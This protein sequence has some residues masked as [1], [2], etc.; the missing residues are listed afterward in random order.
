M[1]RL[2]KL[3]ANFFLL[4]TL[5]T[6]LVYPQGG[7][8]VQN[9]ETAFRVLPDISEMT[10]DEA[11]DLIDDA[12]S[13]A[14]EYKYS[15]EDIE[16]I[17]DLIILFARQGIL[18]NEVDEAIE[19]ERDI[20]ELLY[21]EEDS[22]ECSF[23]GGYY[24]IPAVS[25]GKGDL[26]LCKNWISRS[27]HQTGK[28]IRKK[29]KAIIIGAAAVIAVAT[30]VGIAAALTATAAATA[31]AAADNNNS[32]RAYKPSEP[33]ASSSAT[34]NLYAKMEEPMTSF[35]ENIAN[36]QFFQ[37]S[38]YGEASFKENGRVLGS[39]F[40]HDT[41]NHLSGQFPSQP[42]RETPFNFEHQKIDRKFATDYTPS[43]T[44]NNK[45]PDFNA[46]AYQFQGEREL[47]SGHLTQAVYDFNK[48]IE[49]NP[50]SPIPYLDRGVAHFRLGEYDRS[51][52]DYHEYTAQVEKTQPLSVPAF[53]LGFVQGLPRGI[54]ESGTGFALF[55]SDIV[56]R[57]IHTGIEVW[58]ALKTISTIA[59]SAEWS[60]LSEA[61]APEAHRLVRDWD[62]IPSDERGKLAGYVFG[63]YGADIIIPGALAK[64]VSR[65]VKGA[66]ELGAVY[67]TLQNA[68][69]AL[70]LE[71]ASELGSGVKIGEAMQATRA[72]VALGGE[73]GLSVREMTQ[74]K[75]AG[76]LE[77]TVETI[78]NNPAL[79]ESAERFANAKK[80][81]QPHK[82][83]FMPEA[84]A[85]ELIHEAGIPTFSR[86]KGIPENFQ[87]RI[88]EKG[89]GIEY[90]HPTNEHISVRVMPGSPHSP[91]PHQQQPY[92]V[93]MQSG[94]AVDKCGNMVDKR[95]PEAHISIDEF[96]YR[97]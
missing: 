93:Q 11:M 76:N 17:I 95:A 90:V 46:L 41:F 54:Y 10:Y 32:P 61:L 52:E 3:L 38:S 30:V 36:E 59:G 92:V 19:L 62:S 96:I 82:K 4:F 33:Q 69:K 55:V 42:V 29:K 21:G 15:P 28:F 39:L 20:Q 53:S 18:P 89:A 6:L 45:E 43:Y 50:T 14:I 51:L 86:P 58:G 73:M 83:S 77:R 9:Y 35:K 60:A 91:F 88:S 67:K 47:S 80:M 70:L 48:A 72:T 24:I 57:P 81:L 66:Q 34:P 8:P 74:L 22:Y 37:P 56:T 27:A 16:K 31:A 5:T 26:V 64:A 23:R 1:F 12:E 49:L 78:A 84:R 75:Q 63:K 97:E 68:E 87:V 40:A 65:G 7:L 85:R 13:G 79:C 2:P 44:S 94:K 71:T 25:Y